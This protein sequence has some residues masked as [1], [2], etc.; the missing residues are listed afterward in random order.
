MGDG[1]VTQVGDVSWVAS[2]DRYFLTAVVP[3]GKDTDRRCD[4]QKLDNRDIVEASVRFAEQTIG[5]RS[6][7]E[8]KFVVFVGAKDVTRLDMVQTS[9]GDDAGLT[10]SIEFGWFAV[11]CRPMLAL[12]KGFHT[13]TGNWGIAIILLTLIVKAITLYPTHRSMVS[14]KR[15]QV[16]KPKMDELRQRYGND[17]QRLN[18][19]MMG[20][21]KT[22]KINPF[23]GCLPML[24]QMP[25]WFALY[26]T[27]GNAVELYRSP[28]FGWIHDLTAP[29]HYFVLPILMGAS[30]FAQQL[31]TPQPIEGTQAKM[32]KYFMPGMF[33]VMMLWLPAGLTLYIFI[34]TL[35]SM[36]HQ[37]YLNRKDPT[38]DMAAAL[39]KVI[40][41]AGDPRPSNNGGP[42]RKKARTQEDEVPQQQQRQSKSRRKRRRN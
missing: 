4:I 26:R 16:L 14:M 23:G 30:M 39:K 40:P 2:D 38:R 36:F 17:K 22:Y 19:E 15:M 12:L 34:N 9:G 18:Q 33:T 11:L 5:P 13:F 25:I 1:P 35:L 10:N 21:Y 28:F 24:L 6:K 29:D 37:F 7:I 8:R 3:Q 31:I 42:R 32:M 41:P 20:L 27:L